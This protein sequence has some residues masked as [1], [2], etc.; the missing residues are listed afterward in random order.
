MNRTG[1]IRGFEHESNNYERVVHLDNLL[2]CPWNLGVWTNRLDGYWNFH[3]DPVLRV[4][5]GC[6]DLR[7]PL[8]V[9][10]STVWRKKFVSP[11]VHFTQEITK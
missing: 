4:V 5:F 6:A 2:R 3:S 9:Y 7:N 1:S 11:L 10:F 8:H